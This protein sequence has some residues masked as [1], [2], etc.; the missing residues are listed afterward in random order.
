MYI[1]TVHVYTHSK[2]SNW[3]S[4]CKASKDTKANA[5]RSSSFYMLRAVCLTNNKEKSKQNERHRERKKE[6]G[7]RGKKT[8]LPRHGR[9]KAKHLL[10]QST[11]RNI[12]CECVRVY[13][14]YWK[15]F[16]AI[17]CYGIILCKTQTE[18]LLRLRKRKMGIEWSAWCIRL[19]IFLFFSRWFFAWSHIMHVKQ[20]KPTSFPCK[21]IEISFKIYFVHI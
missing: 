21:V 8:H 14:L 5:Y 20:R 3:I 10:A 7:E 15:H 4:V 17:L 1:P 6:K 11:Y 19:W 2:S 9:Q 18:S 13:E 12:L 16:G